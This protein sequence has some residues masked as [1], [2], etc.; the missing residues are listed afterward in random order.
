MQREEVSQAAE[1]I[2]GQI[3][4]DELPEFGA[5]CEAYFRDGQHP[6]AS[7]RGDRDQALGFGTGAELV[8]LT[9]TILTVVSRVFEALGTGVQQGITKESAGLSVSLFAGVLGHWFKQYRRT[10]AKR[11]TVHPRTA[12]DLRQVH[13]VAL[14]EAVRM[15][16]PESTAT[17]LADAITGYLSVHNTA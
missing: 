8:L 1:A 16:V 11:N 7:A 4:P 14:T 15:G 5:V 13:R 9:P 12:A 17:A 10:T 3:A 6:R 2:V